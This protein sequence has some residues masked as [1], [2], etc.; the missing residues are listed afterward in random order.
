MAIATKTICQGLQDRPAVAAWLTHTKLLYNR[1]AQFYFEVVQAHPGL[2]DLSAHDALTALEHLTHATQANPSPPFPLQALGHEI[3]AYFRRAAIHA[4]LGAAK[5]T[6]TAFAKWQ[7]AKAKAAAKQRAFHR[8]PPQGPRR[9]NHSPVLHKEMYKEMYKEHTNQTVVLK[10]YDGQTWRWVRFVLQGRPVP[11]GWEVGSPALVGRGQHWALHFPVTTAFDTPATAQTQVQAG[12]RFCAV[13]LNLGDHVT[14]CTVL[15]NDA[16]SV[17]AT[18]FIGGNRQRNG[19]RQVLL[20]RIARRRAV[21]ARPASWRTAKRTMPP[22]GSWS[23]ISIGRLPSTSAAA[24]SSSPSAAE[25]PSSSLSTWAVSNPAK[26]ST[27]ARPIAAGSIGSRGGYIRRPGTK[28]GGSG[29]QCCPPQRTSVAT[30]V[31]GNSR[32]KS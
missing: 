31:L 14:V 11:D 27:A 12:T 16:T 20:G 9:W 26:R 17:L 5:A 19:R 7:A 6:A 24:L 23:A 18:R 21:A 3:P 8:R 15:S 4:A 22:A 30:T 28:P 13:D 2:L 25:P 1:I 29:L 32:R 10:L